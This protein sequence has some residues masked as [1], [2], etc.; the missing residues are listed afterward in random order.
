MTFY[1]G[2]SPQYLSPFGPARQI[3]CAKVQALA[4]TSTH[5]YTAKASLFPKYFFHATSP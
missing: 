2:A 1:G 5:L 4:G 3:L